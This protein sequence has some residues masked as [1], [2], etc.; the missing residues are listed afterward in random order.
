[1]KYVRYLSLLSIIVG[2]LYVPPLFADTDVAQ[3]KKKVEAAMPGIV[4]DEFKPSPVAGLYEGVIGTRVAYFSADGAFMFNGDLIDLRAHK[5]LSEAKRATLL[6]KVLDQI[7]E[8]NMIVMGPAKPKRTITVFTDVDCPYCAKL[9]L[10]VPE[11]TKNGVKVRYLLFP[12]GGLGTNT[13][14]RSVAVWC[15]ADRVKAIGIA[16]AGGKIDM[17]TCDNPVARHYQ[18]GKDIGVG[19]TPT[20]Y[21]DDGQ[22][23]PGYMPAARLLEALGITKG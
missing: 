6:T 23:M 9:H 4:F 17:Q 14:N 20:I 8:A 1:M 12:S 5:N 15:A 19:G 10:E 18:L 21:V 7:G 13:Y 22:I 3:L 11:L 2:I 16:K